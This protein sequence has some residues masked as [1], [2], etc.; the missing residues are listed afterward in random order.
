[1][2]LL[3]IGLAFH[4]SAAYHSGDS[5]FAKDI[6]G[7]PFLLI[8]GLTSMIEPRLLLC[9]YPEYSKEIPKKYTAISLLTMVIA[10][11]IALYLSLVVFK[12]WK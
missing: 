5:L 2:F 4:I 7:V 3:G 8:F 1:M 12:E 9:W 6:S 11:C 10:G